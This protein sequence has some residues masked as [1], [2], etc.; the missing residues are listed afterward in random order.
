MAAAPA[1]FRPAAVAGEKIKRGD[2][3]RALALEPTPDIL[4]STRAQ[5]RPGAV[6]VGLRARDDGRGRERAAQARRE[7]AGPRGAQRRDR[8][9]RRLRRRHRTA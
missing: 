3:A 4:A 6:V 1:D 5:R 8:G 2:G 9:G 7:G